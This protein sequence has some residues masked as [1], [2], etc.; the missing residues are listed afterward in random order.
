MPKHTR[1]G[2]QP[3]AQMLRDDGRVI[4]A[5]AR[6]LG[7]DPSYTYRVSY[8]ITAPSEEFRRVVSEFMGRPVEDLFTPDALGAKYKH[9]VNGT[10][11]RPGEASHE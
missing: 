7:L 10:G 11:V 3:F 1:F 5:T 2:P 9:Q 8:G 6:R 4:T